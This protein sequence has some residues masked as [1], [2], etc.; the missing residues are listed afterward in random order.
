MKIDLHLHTTYSD[1]ILTPQ[2]LVK[3][4]KLSGHSVIAVT[5]HD[6]VLGIPSAIKEG[7]DIDITVIPGVEISSYLGEKEYHILGY[8]FDHEDEELKT[9]FHKMNIKRKER[10]IGMLE[11]LKSYYGINISFSEIEK[12]FKS[13]NYGRPHIAILLK[14]KGFVKSILEAFQKYLYDNGPCYAKKFYFSVEDAIDI[15]HRKGG[16]A[17]LAH[18]GIYFNMENIDEF[19]QLMKFGF[20]G[21]EV[22]HPENGEFTNFLLEYSRSNDLIIT[23]GSDY[24]GYLKQDFFDFTIPLDES[25]AMDLIKRFSKKTV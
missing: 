3:F 7:A 14:E 4:A 12:R 19:Y 6:T 13:K 25:Y 20:D 9:L 22:Y 1:G 24:H 16:I 21:I 10:I 11:K 18:A 8:F 23:G 5:D 17:V 2:N 15:I